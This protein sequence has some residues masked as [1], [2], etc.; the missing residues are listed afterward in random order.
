[1]D[2][3]FLKHSILHKPTTSQ[4]HLKG[5]LLLSLGVVLLTA[6]SSWP[7]LVN[8]S[9]PADNDAELH[10]YRIAEMGHSLNEGVLYPRW[11]PDFYHGYGYPI[12]NYYAPLTYYLGYWISLGRPEFAAEAAK[13]LFVGAHMIG[14]LGAYQLGK[15]FGARGGGLL[16]ATAFAFSP[17]IQFINP[18]VRGNL[19]EVFALGCLPWVL[20]SWHNVWQGAGFKFSM[21]AVVSAAATL[22]SHNLTGLMMLGLVGGLSVWHLLIRGHTASLRNVLLAG[23]GFVLLTAFFWLPFLLER[24]YIQLEDVTGKGHYDYRQNFVALP[25]LLK[26]LPQ[27]DYRSSAPI[28]PMTMGP[29]MLVLAGVGLFISQQVAVKTKRNLALHPRNDMLFFGIS[30]LFCIWLTQRSSAWIWRTIP[31]LIYFQ[32]PWRFLGPIATLL[33]PLV[34]GIGNLPRSRARSW[35]LGICVS[36]LILLGLPGLYPRSWQSEWGAIDRLAIVEAELTDRWRGTTSTNDFVPRSVQ[37]IPGPEE[38]VLASYHNPPIDRVNRHTLPKGTEVRV[39][40]DGPQS[41]RFEVNGSEP[42]TLRLYLFDFPGW[43]AYVDGSEVPIEVANPEGFITVDVP[44]GEH[45]VEVRFESTSPRRIGWL[46]TLIG[47][48]MSLIGMPKLF[49]VLAVQDKSPDVEYEECS[50][51]IP[52]VIIGL[53]FLANTLVFNPLGWFRYTSDLG[54]ARPAETTQYAAFGQGP[55]TEEIKLLGYDL[56]HETLQPGRTFNVTLYWMAARPMTQ[57]YQS[58]VHIIGPVGRLWA[59]SDHLNPAGFP[60]DRWPLD[61]Y[62]RD[63]HQLTLQPGAPDGTYTVHVG[64]Y[65]L[66]ENRRLEVIDAA[67]NETNDAAVLSRQLFVTR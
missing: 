57:T 14:I 7:F 39:V 48:M 18:H 19:A 8:D 55:D 24:Q 5:A 47:A 46:L 21:L 27:Q 58:F 15:T 13:V 67:Q 44:A 45:R 50:V 43:T 54:T 66:K 22:L 10:I 16:G 51:G 40:A 52:V 9:L 29:Q 36:G 30:A 25:T 53:F 64:L 63:H 4:T 60:T 31:G 49:R 38:S 26:L 32:F 1:M 62:I 6:L 59:Q 37:M 35:V 65:R 34:A 42:F 11:A 41:N 56:S 33:V 17:Y 12:F 28:A 20:W 3:N 23:V 2:L 61:R